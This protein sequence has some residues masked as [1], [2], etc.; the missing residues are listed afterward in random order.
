MASTLTWNA[1]QANDTASGSALLTN[2]SFTATSYQRFLSASGA[3]AVDVTHPLHGPWGHMIRAGNTVYLV[4]SSV[5]SIGDS[6]LRFVPN[7]VE[8]GFDDITTGTPPSLGHIPNVTVAQGQASGTNAFTVG[9]PEDGSSGLVPVATSSSEAVV[10]SANVIFE[11]SGASRTVYVI[12]GPTPGAATVTVSVSDSAGNQATRAFTVTN[13]QFNTTP[14]L[15]VGGATNSIPPTNTLVNTAVTIPFAI[16][17][18][19]SPKSALFV[20]AAVAPYSSGILA[21]ATLAGDGP[22]TNLSVIVTPQPGVDGVG[23]VQLTCSDPE[24]NNNVQSF[25]VM[26]RPSARVVF[27]DHFDYQG[28]NTKLVDDA[29]RLWTRRNATDPSVFLRSGTDPATSAKVAWLRPASGAENVAAPLIGGPYSPAS[30]A[31]LYTMFKATF[32]DQAA[33]GPGNNIITNSDDSAAFFRLSTGASATTDYIHEPAR[34]ADQ[35]GR[36]PRQFLPRGHRQRQRLRQQHAMDGGF[37]Q[38]GQ[39]DDR[40]RA[41]HLHHTL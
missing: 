33:S 35:R 5:N 36:E 3:N 8:L 23:V 20:S 2:G 24:G 16:L 41:H 32:A 29:P 1:A 34:R 40:N 11:G 28:S 21:A 10:P 17:D 6:G 9:D 37:S 31:V 25:C 4:L 12:G 22:N 38:A 27:V 19:E 7:S 26:V 13:L 14:I 39:P 18:A 30:S 15:V